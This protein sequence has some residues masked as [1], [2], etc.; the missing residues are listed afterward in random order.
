M[1]ALLINPWIYDFKCYDFWMKPHG[2]LRIATILKNNN[3]SVDLI[4]CMDRFSEEM[5]NYEQK[6]DEYGKGHFYSEEI[7]KPDIYIK[8]PR[9]YKRYGMPVDLFKN[10]IEKLQKPDIILITSSMTYN[11]EGVFLAID[12]LKEKFETTK[13][14]LGGIYATLCTEHAKKHSKANFVWNGPVENSFFRLLKQYTGKTIEHDG[15]LNEVLPD[16]SFYKDTP[17]AAVRLS[18]GCPFNCTYCAIKNFHGNYYQRQ[19]ENVLK[20]LKNYAEKG[21]QDIAFYDDALLYKNFYI[22]SVLKEIIKENFKFRF[23]TPNGLHAVY[24]DI[25]MAELLKNAGFVDLRI[26]LESSDYELQKITG[27]KVNDGSFKNALY[28]LKNAGFKGNDTGVYILAGLPG[29]NYQYVLKDVQYLMDKKVKIKLA[30]YSPI[31][32]TVDF[33][34]IKS[35]IRAQIAAEPLKQNEHYFL[36]L[37]TDFTWEDNEKIKLIINEYNKTL[38]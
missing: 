36:T 4:D 29:Q 10:K 1:H 21:I 19:K 13:I 5:K 14:I 33:L 26:S 25:E 9:K 24:I 2:L 30:N 3:F 11:Y 38:D 28:N 18:Y 34:K 6:H 35:D 12:I 16:Y 20:E 17:Y 8:I 27:G 7:S 23:H 22:K 32:G 31:P 37:N 15:N